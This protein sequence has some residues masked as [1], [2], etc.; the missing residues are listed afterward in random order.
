[1]K[2][3]KSTIIG[4]VTAFLVLAA[5][6]G[7]VYETGINRPP[8]KYAHIPSYTKD[9]IGEL[10]NFKGLGFTFSDLGPFD[11]ENSEDIGQ[12]QENGWQNEPDDN[13]IVYYK[14]DKQAVW[15]G[16]AQDVLLCAR[17][18]TEYLKELFGKYYYAKDM[19]G[20]RLA[21]YLPDNDALYR[22]TVDTLLGKKGYNASSAAG[23]IITQVGPLGCLTK[24]IVLNPICFDK[25]NRITANN[26]RRVLKHEMAHYV[27]FTSLDYGKNISH[28][29]W[30]SEGIAEYFSFN[31]DNVVHSNDSINF[32]EKNCRLNGEFP[33]E[34]NSAYWAGE[35]FFCYLEKK[36]GLD[37]VKQF[38]R[39]SYEMATDS[40]FTSDSISVEALHREWVNDMRTLP[41]DSMAI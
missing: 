2:N 15:Q 11:W 20:R 13:F 1:M 19:N 35:S 28:Y 30:V 9:Y 10:G 25:E 41:A 24:G 4:T 32:I 38:L 31:R 34:M 5:I 40:I 12:D 17:E 26:Y 22:H 16:H 37:M 14:H 29:Q 8:L 23:V 6:I 21:I 3:S 39:K 18:N 36:G 7:K 33:L 27:F